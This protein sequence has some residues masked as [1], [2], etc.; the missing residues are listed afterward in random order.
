[1]SKLSL[2]EFEK[3]ASLRAMSYWIEHCDW[4]CPILF[5]LEINDFESA[6]H[7]WPKQT[8]ATE[9]ALI[10][11]WR[12]LLFGASAIP[13]EELITTI[14]ISYQE[15]CTVLERLICAST[16]TASPPVKLRH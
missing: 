12:E 5:G 9:R 10:G 7:N 3:T 15:A 6:I 14:G 8:E 4:E 1:M 11:A 13:R 2:T 16:R